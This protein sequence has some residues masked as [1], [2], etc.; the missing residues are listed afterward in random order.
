M[1]PV[2]PVHIEYHPGMDGC[3]RQ[4]VMNSTLHCWVWGKVGTL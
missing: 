2:A 4:I 3:N 1:R